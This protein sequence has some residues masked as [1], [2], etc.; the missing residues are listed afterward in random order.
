M[1]TACNC[2]VESVYKVSLCEL[3]S[4]HSV[5]THGV[6]PA[7]DGEQAA[8]GDGDGG[9][10]GEVRQRVGGHVRDGRVGGELEHHDD[11]LLHLLCE[12]QRRLQEEILLRPMTGRE[13]EREPRAEE[14]GRRGR[15]GGE[16]RRGGKEG[17][18]MEG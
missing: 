10:D 1:H 18:K 14:D 15:T 7:V 3:P 6:V 12:H 5:L 17:G 13:R 9:G 8:A 4:G 11:V 2:I 16:D